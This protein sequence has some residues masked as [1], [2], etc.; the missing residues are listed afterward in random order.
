MRFRFITRMTDATALRRHRKTSKTALLC[1]GLSMVLQMTIAWAGSPQVSPACATVKRHAIP[2][3]RS[4]ES[5]LVATDFR[6]FCVNAYYRP[7]S[8]GHPLIFP[9]RK[10]PLVYAGL[11][12]ERVSAASLAT[13]PNKLGSSGQAILPS[14]APSLEPSAKSDYAI[15]GS[16]RQFGRLGVGGLISRLTE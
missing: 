10:G 3:R 14:R 4:R 1:K 7:T 16:Q 5:L 9:S 2:V 8:A 12:P 6:R 13:P 11:Q 15:F